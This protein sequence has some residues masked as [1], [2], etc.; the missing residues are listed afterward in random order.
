LDTHPDQIGGDCVF[1]G[2]VRADS[3]A[4]PATWKTLTPVSA[5]VPRRRSLRADEDWVDVREAFAAQPSLA[6]A[7]GG[8]LTTTSAHELPLRPSMQTL[9]WVRGK[10]VDQ[11]GNVVA[12]TTSGY[13]WRR[14][15]A[16]SSAVRCFGEC[17]VAAQTLEVP[18]P[19]HLGAPPRSSRALAFR[20]FAPW[21]LVSRVDGQGVLLYRTRFDSSW[22]AV[23]GGHVL[24]HIRIDAAFN[25]WILSGKPAKVVIFE[26][27]AAIQFVFELIGLAW[28]IFLLVQITTQKARM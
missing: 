18:N 23:A 4:I 25:G 15:S 16:N 12:T 14:V 1:F 22:M 26:R 21:L 5:V 28:M 24:P 10:L 17:V 9:L 13:A 20:M 19:R 8:A 3:K 2:D 7:L 27:L 6:Q 11:S